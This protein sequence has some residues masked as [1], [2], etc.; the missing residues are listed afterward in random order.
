VVE[1]LQPNVVQRIGCL[2]SSEALM[3]RLGGVFSTVRH[4]SLSAWPRN[5]ISVAPLDV[6]RFPALRSLNI[7]GGFP[8][9]SSLARRH[10]ALPPLEEL[11]LKADIGG[12]WITLLQKCAK[13][14][15]R[16]N[17]R[18]TFLR[19]GA[20]T[21]VIEFPMLESLAIYD[22]VH[23]TGTQLLQAITPALTSYSYHRSIIIPTTV[24]HED[25]A[26]VAHL[27]TTEIFDL[28]AYP[29]LRILQI[30]RPLSII[31][32]CDELT[33]N[34]NLCP[35]LETIQIPGTEWIDDVSVRHCKRLLHR[36]NEKAGSN[37]QLIQDDVWYHPI[38]GCDD[39]ACVSVHSICPS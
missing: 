9:P 36:R 13:T 39:G 11:I 28:Q 23:A 20:A 5:V 38:A 1:F 21:A 37:I 26:K 34:P 29:R 12:T 17:M 22:W 16:L 33:R 18:G 19:Q 10:L 2:S 3:R 35:Y 4:L 25:V 32:T 6:N 27:R 31:A 14:L 30:H 8:D 15:K 7:S 24:H